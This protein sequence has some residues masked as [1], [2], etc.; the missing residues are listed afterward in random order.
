M[1]I[2][3]LIIAS[4]SLAIC[5]KD[6]FHINLGASKRHLNK[7]MIQPVMPIVY[8]LLGIS[9]KGEDFIK[10]EN[11]SGKDDILPAVREL[12]ERSELK[13]RQELKHRNKKMSKGDL[14]KEVLCLIDHFNIVKCS[15]LK[16]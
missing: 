9:E 6:F 7:W 11:E 4:V 1:L 2:V 5:A 14:L 15:S 13:I 10:K 3:L 12:I 8:G 16:I